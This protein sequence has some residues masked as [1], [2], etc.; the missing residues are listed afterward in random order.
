MCKVNIL[1]SFFSVPISAG[2]VEGFLLLLYCL[3]NQS[4]YW[5]IICDI[6]EVFITTYC[7]YYCSYHALFGY[8]RTLM[9][10]FHLTK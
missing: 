5:Y 1:F 10:V 7:L 3:S 2:M 9:G 6:T 8:V 4:V